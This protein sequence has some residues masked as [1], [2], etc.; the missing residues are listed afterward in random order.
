M[1]DQLEIR[2]YRLPLRQPWRSARG[3]MGER[4]GWLVCAGAEGLHGY[5]DCAPLPEAGTETEEQAGLALTLWRSLVL[6]RSPAQAL[7][8]LDQDPA[9]APAARHALECALLDL[10]AQGAGL[11]LR[12]WFD[13]GAPNQIEVNGTLGALAEVTA[14]RVQTACREGLRVLKLKVGLEAPSVELRRLRDLSRQLPIGV[15]LRLDANGAWDYDAAAPLVEALNALPIESLEEPLRHPDFA[16]LGRL[17][18]LACFPLA[19]DETLRQGE[20]IDTLDHLPVRR[21]VLKPAAVGGLR[22][23]LDLARRAAT[24]GKEVVVTS[25]IESAA[26][27]WPSLQLATLLPS[28]L[29]HGLTTSSWLARDLGRPPARGGRWMGLDSKAGSGFQPDKNRNPALYPQ[30]T[31]WVASSI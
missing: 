25:L 30:G 21:L 9:S 10:S 18:T 28:P 14:E 31:D 3:V 19:L 26:G 15:A 5:G 4:R 27:I 22:Q 12:H 8:D 16:A 24:A 1:I 23:T 7:A 20:V 17:Q 11:P 6:G 29:P 13:P 2:P